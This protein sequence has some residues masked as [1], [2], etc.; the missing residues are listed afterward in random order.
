MVIQG[1]S[2]ESHDK[3]LFP[4]MTHVGTMIGHPLWCP[5]LLMNVVALWRS[6]FRRIIREYPQEKL[7]RETLCHFGQE[8]RKH[9]CVWKSCS[10][11]EVPCWWRPR[12]QWRKFWANAHPS[13]VSSLRRSHFAGWQAWWRVQRFEY[14][15]CKHA[16][17]KQHGPW[18][19]VSVQEFL[20]R[21]VFLSVCWILFCASETATSSTDR[22][23]RRCVQHISQQQSTSTVNSYQ[24]FRNPSLRLELAAVSVRSSCM[25]L[26]KM[27]HG[28]RLLDEG[29][30]STCVYLYLLTT[31]IATEKWHKNTRLRVLSVAWGLRSNVSHCASGVISNY[32][33]TKH[34]FQR[35][36]TDPDSTP[37]MTRQRNCM[38]Q[39][40]G[41]SP[42]GSS[43]RG[44][45]GRREA[46]PNCCFGRKQ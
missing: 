6:Q 28:Q 9:A 29:N 20:G 43:D 12:A 38:Q 1:R 10:A 7:R 30:T 15:C 3:V 44:A 23:S 25:F 37:K 18:N 11:S 42:V 32:F 36:P 41:L 33:S 2:A 17:V 13:G 46:A 31:V 39:Q 14:I 4:R 34:T 27:W 24:T 8:Q 5:L 19:F 21:G 35:T 45:S 22:R 40:N 26:W 16:E